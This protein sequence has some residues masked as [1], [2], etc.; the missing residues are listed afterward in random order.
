MFGDG[1]LHAASEGAS[2]HML[3]EVLILQKSVTDVLILL[4]E[5]QFVEKVVF[6]QLPLFS[7]GW[8]ALLWGLGEIEILL[9]LVDVFAVWN[10]ADT[11][12]LGAK[13]LKFAENF[14]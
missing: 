12:T 1:S 6:E 3:D 8:K 5:T 9:F 7:R 13:S 14:L 10:A 11:E 2:F 4:K